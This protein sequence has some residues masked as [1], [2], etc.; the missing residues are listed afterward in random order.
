MTQYQKSRLARRLRVALKE[1]EQFLATGCA[2]I[3]TTQS[4]LL[5]PPSPMQPRTPP[6][7]TQTDRRADMTDTSGEAV[8]HQDLIE[9]LRSAAE[10]AVSDY[11]IDGDFN[12]QVKHH[13]AS[14]AADLIATLSHQLAEAQAV[15]E[16]MRGLLRRDRWGG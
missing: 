12:E 8:E 13:P 3:L 5:G 6:M 4:Q 1:I 11:Y 2:M 16:R 10:S 7:T 9:E 14:Q 15:I